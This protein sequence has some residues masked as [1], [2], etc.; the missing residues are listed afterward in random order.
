MAYCQVPGRRFVRFFP[1]YLITTLRP[2]ARWGGGGGDEGGGDVE[3]GVAGGR[4]RG[5]G[6]GGRTKARGGSKKRKVKAIGVGCERNR[7][8]TFREPG[9]LKTN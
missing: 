3:V 2:K 4:G 1:G 8:E 6:G 9:H 5:G 7:E